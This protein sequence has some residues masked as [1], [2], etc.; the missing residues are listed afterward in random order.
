M[1]ET[2]RRDMSYRVLRDT[3]NLIRDEWVNIGVVLEDAKKQRARARLIEEPSELAD[4]RRLHPHAD[5]NLLRALPGEFDVQLA[6][7]GASIAW[8]EKMEQT[9]SNTLQFSPRQAVFAEDFDAELDRLYHDKVAPPAQQDRAAALVESTRAWIRMRLND[10]FRRHRILAK[11]KKSVKV[12]QFTQT[13]DPLRIDYAYRYNGTRGYLKALSLGRDPAQAKV[14]AYTAE[15]IRTRQK[16]SEF[17]AITEVAPE[18]EDEQ[19]Q[20]I[21]RLFDQQKITIVPLPQVEMFAE[22]L[23]PRLPG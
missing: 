2:N 18:R 4:V 21:V 1:P 22:R 9:L 11:M 13:G 19:H 16:N 8:I 5:E 23:R 15:C 17:T 20:F 6:A 14:L 7:T 12:E 10:D 3:P